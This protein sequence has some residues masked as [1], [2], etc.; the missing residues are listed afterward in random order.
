[1]PP[2]PYVF[3][4]S[5]FASW[6]AEPQNAAFLS[7]HSDP[8]QLET[9]KRDFARFNWWAET[10]ALTVPNDSGFPVNIGNEKCIK[11]MNEKNAVPLAAD[12]LEE[13]AGMKGETRKAGLY[14]R[15][16]FCRIRALD[17]LYR[18]RALGEREANF[19]TT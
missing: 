5:V 11:L 17:R 1:M 9:I 19:R 7:S 10:C 18:Q 14:V 6:S 16:V 2:T 13:I 12:A 4:P 15:I 8:E 3:K